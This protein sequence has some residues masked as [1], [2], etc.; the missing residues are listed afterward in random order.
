MKYCWNLYSNQDFCLDLNEDYNSTSR[1]RKRSSGTFHVLQEKGLFLKQQKNISKQCGKSITS[2]LH[3]KKK[4]RKNLL[5]E[6]ATPFLFNWLSLFFNAS[7]LCAFSYINTIQYNL[8]LNKKLQAQQYI[9]T[10][11]YYIKWTNSSLTSCFLNSSKRFPA[12]VTLCR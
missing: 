10:I 9:I 3:V 5:H 11:H 8:L 12:K 4:K 1:F 6:N 7:S 2:L